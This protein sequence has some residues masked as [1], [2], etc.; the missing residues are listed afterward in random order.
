L[1]IALALDDEGRPQLVT[2]DEDGNRERRTIAPDEIPVELD[3]EYRRLRDD[4]R[5]ALAGGHT[6][7]ARHA[8]L[9][10]IGAI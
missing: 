2:E 8:Y 7:E 5:D 9:W 1:I 4:H 10:G 6:A 3:A